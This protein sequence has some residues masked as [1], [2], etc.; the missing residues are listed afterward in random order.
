VDVDGAAE[1]VLVA[2]SVPLE[3]EDAGDD[4]IAARGVGL[5]DLA[6]GRRLLKTLPGVRAA[7]FL[8]TCMWPSGVRLLPGVSPTPNLEVEIL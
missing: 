7:D 8:A 5:E 2:V 4:R 1:G 6:G 3:P